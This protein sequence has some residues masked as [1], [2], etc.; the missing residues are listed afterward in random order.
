MSIMT[1]LAVPVVA[2][3]AGIMAATMLAVTA[4]TAEATKTV[5]PGVVNLVGVQGQ[6]LLC[7]GWPGNDDGGAGQVARSFRHSRPLT[8]RLDV[9]RPPGDR[10]LCQV[11]E[12]D[13]SFGGC[14]N[15]NV[16]MGRQDRRIAAGTGRPNRMRV[17]DDAQP[18]SRWPVPRPAPIPCEAPVATAAFPN[19]TKPFLLQSA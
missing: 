3:I 7:P 19:S 11:E 6:S 9:T 2:M 5:A 14:G 17:G 13:T 18:I 4:A 1:P 15:G 16:A 10:P 12:C 8:S